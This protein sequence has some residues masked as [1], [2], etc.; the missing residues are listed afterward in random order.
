MKLL[1]LGKNGQVGFELQRALS[2]LGEIVVVGHAECDL[3]DA[4]ALRHAIE[5]VAPDVII[6]A[7]A[8]TAVDKAE[9]EP[10]LAKAVNGVAPGILGAAARD[11]GALVIHYSTDYVFDGRKS[12]AYTEDD[13]PNPLNVYGASKLAGERALLASGARCLILRTSWVFGVHGGNFVK[14]ILRLARERDSLSVVAD[15]FGAPTSAA[16]IADVTA[17]IVARYRWSC[18]STNTDFPYGLYH[19]TAAGRTSWHEYAQTI[20]AA[21]QAAGW[22]LKLTPAAVRPIPSADYPTAARRPANSCL[23]TTKLAQTFGLV[24]PD[25]R[26]GLAHVLDTLLETRP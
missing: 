25:W 24:L 6:N 13:A 26:A 10:A 12:D 21:A 17:L 20:I 2:P 16:L 4:A 5:T 7:A 22:P 18:R 3:A 19:L 15:Q 23:A 1:L 14:T 11:R 8:Y 9:V